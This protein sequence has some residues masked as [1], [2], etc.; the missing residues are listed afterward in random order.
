MVT[1]ILF[2]NFSCIN[3]WSLISKYDPRIKPSIPAPV[4]ASEESPTG[5]EPHDQRVK[6]SFPQMEGVF[7]LSPLNYHQVELREINTQTRYTELR[8]RE[9]LTPSNAKA[10]ETE[11]HAMETRRPLQPVHRATAQHC[12]SR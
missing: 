2:Y 9:S 7:A 4:C 8:L 10:K 6:F 12:S 11:L 5:T 1:K 3:R